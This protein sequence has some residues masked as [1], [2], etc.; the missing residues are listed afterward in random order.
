MDYIDNKM[1]T[2]SASYL[3]IIGTPYLVIITTLYLVII[4]TPYFLW[5]NFLLLFIAV[6]L[7]HVDVIG[8]PEKNDSI[9]GFS[10]EDQTI[11]SPQVKIK[12]YLKLFYYKNVQ[13]LQLLNPAISLKYCEIE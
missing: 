10:S 11:E 13:V 4:G 3:A 6:N 8:Y 5:N 9:Y 1:H 2:K 7:K 12:L